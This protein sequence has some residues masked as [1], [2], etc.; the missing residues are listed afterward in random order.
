MVNSLLIVALLAGSP[1]LPPE[2]QRQIGC[3]ATLA[4][5]ASEQE[6]R[7]ATEWPALKA[8]GARFAQVV[9]EGVMK[10]AGWSREQVRDAILAAVAAHQ[11]STTAL[12][13][14]ADLPPSDIETCIALMEAVAPAPLPPT[15]PQ[16]AAMLARAYDET[17]AREGLTSRAKDLKTLASVLDYRAREALRAEGKSGTEV[18][19]TMV[20][21][22]GIIVAEAERRAADNV[23]AGL[24]YG[25]CIEMARP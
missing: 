13:K 6:R 18:D 25:A 4:I 9:G 20:E 1:A 24:D 23:S 15:L 5:V 3:V 8:R 7:G 17:H 12:G 21:T 19:R 16:C 2:R 11:K 14:P 22:H 10:D